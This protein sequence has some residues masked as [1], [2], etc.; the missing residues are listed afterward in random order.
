[1]LSLSWNLSGFVEERLQMWRSTLQ[2]NM[3]SKCSTHRPGM[4]KQWPKCLF[5]M[6]SC[7]CAT[8]FQGGSGCKVK[9]GKGVHTLPIC[10]SKGTN[11]PVKQLVWSD[12]ERLAKE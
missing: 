3:V 6:R 1:M 9:A 7:F 4:P 12:L 11:S 5:P 2:A 10:S 8:R